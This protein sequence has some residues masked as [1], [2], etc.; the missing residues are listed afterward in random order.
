MISDQDI[1]PPKNFTVAVL[2]LSPDHEK[3]EESLNFFKS[4]L[5]KKDIKIF[6]IREVPIRPEYCGY[7]ALKDLPK[8]VQVFVDLDSLN[9][10]T[11]AEINLELLIIR[12]KVEQM[13]REQSSLEHFYCASFSTYSLSY[14]AL[15]TTDNL[16]NFYP[17]LKNAKLK[18]SI[19]LFHQ[20]FSTNTYPEW[21]LAQPF[22]MLAHNGE[23]NTIDGNRSWSLAR[24]NEL[25]NKNLSELANIKELIN[26]NG[27]DS[28]SLDNL[29][30]LLNLGGIDLKTSVKMLM[31]P[32]YQ[33]NPNYTQRQK[34][35]F[36]YYSH[37]MEA[38]DG[39]AAIVA[40]NHKEAICSLD[41][42]GL[43]PARYCINK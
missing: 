36:E 18:S 37:F 17:D 13:H 8:I 9:E 12:K 4:E 35:M 41:R 1:N 14:K 31:P 6:H 32:A 38:W 23:I 29:L 20:R 2:Y 33:K 11:E 19:C 7:R 10:K 40:F 39:P 24:N 26:Q 15:V 3:Y 21:R 28:M 42:N 22:R 30:E 34:H 25:L 5:E 27:S 16:I 43:R